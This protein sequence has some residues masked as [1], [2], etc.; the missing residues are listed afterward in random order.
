MEIKVTESVNH[1]FSDQLTKRPAMIF[2]MSIP[3]LN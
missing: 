3:L 1:S 2:G